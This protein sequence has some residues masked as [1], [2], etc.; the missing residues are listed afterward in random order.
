[1]ILRSLLYIIAA[2][3]VLGWL[4]GFFYFKTAGNL[5]HILLV[6]ALVS[7]FIGL[8]SRKEID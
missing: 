2:V 6:L 4:L 8:F 5:I 1:M 3:L 7:V